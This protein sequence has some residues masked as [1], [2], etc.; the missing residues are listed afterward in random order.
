MAPPLAYIRS[1]PGIMPRILDNIEYDLLVALDLAAMRTP[2]KTRK[3]A[4]SRAPNTPSSHRSRR[5]FAANNASTL[6]RKTAIEL[7]AGG[8][9]LFPRSD[10][11]TSP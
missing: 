11:R 8:P 4:L 5:N 6:A 2:K 7:L 1:D 9:G 3:E 10:L